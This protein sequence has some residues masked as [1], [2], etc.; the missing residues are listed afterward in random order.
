MC[1]KFVCYNIHKEVL[2]MKEKLTVTLDPDVVTQAKQEAAEKNI[3]ISQCINDHLKKC[4]AEKQP[5]E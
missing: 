1:Y 4:Y 3:S 2:L 5:Q